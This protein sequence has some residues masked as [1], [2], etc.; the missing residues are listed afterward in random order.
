MVDNPVGESRTWTRILVPLALLGVFRLAASFPLPGVDTSRLERLG[1][2]S[3]GK[4]IALGISPFVTG[5]VVV[6]LWSFV[7]PMGRKLRRG[8]IA[9]RS[10]LTISAIRV[11][12]TVALW[13]AIAIA[14]ALQQTFAPDGASLVPNPGFLLIL[15]SVTTLVAV[16]TLAFLAAKLVSRWGVGNGFCLIILLQDVWHASAQVHDP[17]P[18]TRLVFGNL[19]EVVAWLAAIGL[20]V[21][22][23]A[24]R[25]PASLQD[26]KQGT[27]PLLILPAFSQGILP[28]LWAYG[29]FKFLS[30]LS[31]VYALPGAVEQSPIALLFMTV[32]IAAFSLGTFRLFSGYERLEPNLPTGVLPPEGGVIHR[33]SL[34]QSTALLVVLGVSF[35]AGEWFFNFRFPAF[36]FPI[37]IMV[38]ALGFDLVSEWRFR[39]RHGDGVACLIEMDNVY[40]ACYLHGLL[41]KRGFD[42]VIRAFNYRSLFFDLGP[43][44]KMELLVPAAELKLLR[45]IIRPERIEIV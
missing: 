24:R 27:I 1:G 9:G 41:S 7:I 14:T 16:A 28:V 13:Q 12:L 8:G 32:L 23:F 6:E 45:E 11:G 21:W 30:L 44:V 33:Q 31:S 20:L 42:S 39:Y 4:V 36:W 29:I 2:S 19:F 3:T 38:V 40:C 15:S 43:I 18:A 10:K 5:F 26:S 25:P 35:P 22:R 37:L 17:A 34:L